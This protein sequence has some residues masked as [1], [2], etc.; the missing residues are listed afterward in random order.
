MKLGKNSVKNCPKPLFIF[1]CEIILQIGS[2]RI[3]IRQYLAT[4]YNN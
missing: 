3:D 2:E 4:V 1:I